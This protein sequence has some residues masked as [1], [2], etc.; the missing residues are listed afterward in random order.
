MSNKM[1]DI[2]KWFAQYFFPAAGALYAA[3]AKIWGFPYGE[4][5]VGT[6]AA[7]DIFLGAVMGISSANYKGDGTLEID[8]TSRDDKSMYRFV[9]NTPIED[10]PNRSKVTLKVN[11]NATFGSTDISQD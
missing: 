10:L 3:L 11:P 5:V 7:I 8:D 2:L 6:L 4:E 9:L 1:Y